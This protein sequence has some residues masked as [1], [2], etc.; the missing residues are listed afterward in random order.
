MV[1]AHHARSECSAKEGGWWVQR[2]LY[3]I[4]RASSDECRCAKAAGTVWHKLGRCEL[5]EQTRAEFNQPALF[6]Y[7]GVAVWDPLYSRGVPARP[8]IPKHPQEREWWSREKEGA[9]RYASGDVYSDGAAE[10]GFFR[11]VR[12]GW[13]AV[14]VSE[15][16]EV[17]WTA[18]GILGGQH[19]CI[20]R[21]ELTAV[22]EVLRIAIP[23]LRIHV[24]NAQVVQGFRKGREWCVSSKSFAADLW[25]E[26]WE[27]Y[28]DI[29]GGSGC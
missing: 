7:G 23:P 10:G 2:R 5:A 8:K 11:A 18:G 21:A 1:L 28:D 22:L 6:K 19:T 4:G 3:A 13:W 20:F 9:E 26:V 24:D 15:E 29:G 12:A 25:R 16:G 27:V 14:A 17:L